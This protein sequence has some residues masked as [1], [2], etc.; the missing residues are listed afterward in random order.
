MTLLCEK[1]TVAKS[2]E[3]KTGPY[4]AESSKEGY[5][6]KSVSFNQLLI[7]SSSPFFLFSSRFFLFILQIP[8]HFI[9]LF[10][11]E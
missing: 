9:L 3:V 5:G 2:N 8:F 10:H 4:L 6:S 11:A 1:I 7:L